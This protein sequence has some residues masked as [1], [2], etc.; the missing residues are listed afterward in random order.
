MLASIIASINLMLNIIKEGDWELMWIFTLL[1]HSIIGHIY[2]MLY[3]R[4]EVPHII[5]I[6]YLRFVRK[7]EVARFVYSIYAIKVDFKWRIS[8]EKRTV[9]RYTYSLHIALNREEYSRV[10]IWKSIQLQ[11]VYISKWFLKSASNA[12][13]FNTNF[14]LDNVTAIY[15]LC[16]LYNNYR[17]IVPI[18]IL[19][20]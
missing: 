19:I 6:V 17:C 12:L 7:S 9:F 20:F 15:I 16:T 4:S 18:G 1:T 11:K 14:L 10:D 13:V 2:P 8:D 3:F 5:A